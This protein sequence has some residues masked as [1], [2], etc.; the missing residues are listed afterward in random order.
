MTFEDDMRRAYDDAG[1]AWNEGPARVYRALAQ[2]VLDAAGDVAGATALDV[3]TGSGV[4]AD[5]LVRRGARV[6]ALDLSLGMLR[7]AS[8]ERPPAVVA[9]VRALPFRSRC[10]DLA[11]ASFVLNHL[12]DPVPAVLELVRVARPGGRVLATSFDGE[13]VHPAKGVVDEVAGSFGFEPPAWYEA[14]RSSV[15]PVLSSAGA[16]ADAGRG[17]GLSAVRVERVPVAVELAPR[18]LAGWRLGMAHLAPFVARL[19]AP[20]RAA[21][22]AAT[23]AALVEVPQEVHFSVLLLV[24]E[25]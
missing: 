24:G 16:F 12:E 20:D 17:G 7:R 11:T 9:D 15:Q 18:E 21:L 1:E 19:A 4:L 6:L 8:A 22:F 25:V 3:G 10:V 5:E 13:A 2:P 23:E 14:M